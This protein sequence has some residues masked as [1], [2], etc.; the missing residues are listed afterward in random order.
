VGALALGL[1]AAFV[2]QASDPYFETLH[3]SGSGN[4]ASCHD[5]LYDELG[6]D[7]SIQSEWSAT[8]MANAARDPLFQAKLASELLRNPG[9]EAVLNDKCTRCHAPMANE[10]ARLNPD[11]LQFFDGGF[12]DPANPYHDAAMDGVSCTL[13]HQIEDTGNLGTP[14]ATSGSFT[15]TDDRVAYGPFGR[16]RIRP[17]QPES[18]Y[19]PV[20]APHTLDSAHCASC[21]NLMTPVLDADSGSATGAE[22]PEQMVY[23][24]WEHSAFTEGGELEQSCQNCHMARADGVKIA[25]RPRNLPA[26]DDFH[27]HGFYGGNTL[28]LDILDANREVLDV[29]DGDFAASIEATR[30]TLRSAAELAIE[31]VQ[32]DGDALSVEVRVTNK[33]GHKLPAS[34]PSRRAFIHLRVTDQS[35]TTLFE[36]GRPNADGTVRGV[37]GD[38]GAVAYEPHY[39]E[40]T[41]E[42]Q[43]QVYEPIMGDTNDQQTYT[44]L[45][46]AGYLKDNRIPPKGFHKATV[47]EQIAVRGLAAEDPDFDDGSDRV[48]Y[49]IDLP[50]NARG[51]QISAALIYQTLAAGFLRDLARDAEDP[52]V[53]R[54]LAMYE[55]SEVRFETIAE[56]GTVLQDVGGG[57]R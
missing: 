8:M 40:I 18:G 39:Q 46:A 1:T 23:S 33:I 4:C 32:L 57:R 36:S 2:A 20:L 7:V 9:V 38:T 14:D 21:H 45:R 29:G 41:R 19:T 35:G 55:A 37:D 42:D 34:F 48:T 52:A 12:A 30:Q 44:L 49:R 13:C 31:D 28:V 16:P 54:F 26:R 47:P 15:I 56:T 50:A 11:D 6:E 43:V 51:I 5:G 25:N 27:R 3:F 53:E 10:E 22:F 24:E 17:M